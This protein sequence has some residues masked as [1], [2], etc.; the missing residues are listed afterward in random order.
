MDNSTW[1]PVALRLFAFSV[2]PVLLATLHLRVGRRREGSPPS[3]RGVPD[4][5]VHARR[6]CGW[7][8][9]L[10]RSRLHARYGR[11][12]DRLAEGQSVPTG[13]GFRQSRP[14]GLGPHRSR[15]EGR[16]SG[17]D[18][19]RDRHRRGGGDRG[20]C[21]RHGSRRQ[22]GSG[23]LDPEHR[24]PPEAGPVDTDPH[25]ESSFRV[26]RGW[27]IFPSIRGGRPC[28]GPQGS[29]RPSLAPASG[30]GSRSASPCRQH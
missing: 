3:G 28:S 15:A 16:L 7:A 13:D 22:P 4:L 29:S 1:T 5:S 11:G 21:H 14:R 6:G 9:R 24:E 23:K 17:G 26:R 2:L 27:A 10:L 12:V 20:S 25:R 30:S 19:D 8:Q 18:G